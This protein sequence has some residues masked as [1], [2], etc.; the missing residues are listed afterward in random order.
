[1]ARSFCVKFLFRGVI[2]AQSTMSIWPV[3]LDWMVCAELGCRPVVA[4]PQNHVNTPRIDVRDRELAALEHL[5]KWNSESGRHDRRAPIRT[6]NVV[7]RRQDDSTQFDVVRH[8]YV[9]C[10]GL[11]ALVHFTPILFH[12]L[13][14]RSSSTQDGSLTPVPSLTR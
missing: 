8:F 5:S 6:E 10:T 11:Y 4:A 12:G 14:Q 9:R 1:M 2:P 3:Q 7:P 13:G